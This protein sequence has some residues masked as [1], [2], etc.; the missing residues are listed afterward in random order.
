MAIGETDSL[1]LAKCSRKEWKPPS[2]IYNQIKE[3]LKMIED[4]DFNINHYFREANRPADRL[5]VLSHKVAGVK[6]FNLFCELPSN[7]R[8]LVH[9]DKWSLPTFKNKPAKLATSYM[10]L[11][12]LSNNCHLFCVGIECQSHLY[13]HVQSLGCQAQIV[14]FCTS[15][16]NGP[17]N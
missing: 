16:I 1:I 10:I 13:D 12:D 15:M 4:H 3:I 2:K 5:A 9:T 8:G 14:T 7:I 11:L 6:T 17:L